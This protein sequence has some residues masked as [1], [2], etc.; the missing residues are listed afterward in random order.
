MLVEKKDEENKAE[1]EN[2]DDDADQEKG[3]KMYDFK[4]REGQ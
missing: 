3:I 4:S 1:K 2:L